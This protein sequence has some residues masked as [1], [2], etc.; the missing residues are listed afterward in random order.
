MLDKRPIPVYMMGFP[1]GIQREV[2]AVV[3][4]ELRLAAQRGW[5]RKKAEE[6][7]EG[8]LDELRRLCIAHKIETLAPQTSLG[9]YIA[10]VHANV[11]HST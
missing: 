6:F 2:Y 1:H 5:S 10:E 9:R 4:H 8:D 3:Q 7:V 11:R